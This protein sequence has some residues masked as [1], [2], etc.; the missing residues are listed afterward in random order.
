MMTNLRGVL[1]KHLADYINDPQLRKI[2]C[3]AVNHAAIFI[4]YCLIGMLT[5]Q[6]CDT[7]EAKLYKTVK[8]FVSECRSDRK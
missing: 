5:T 4:V 7:G 3:G 1:N 6:L 8:P 2:R